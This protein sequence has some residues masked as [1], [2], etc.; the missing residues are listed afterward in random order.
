MCITKALDSVVRAPSRVLENLALLLVLY[1][2]AGMRRSTHG[3][4]LACWRTGACTGAPWRAHACWLMDA[5]QNEHAH[6]YAHPQRRLMP[7]GLYKKAS[8]WLKLLIDLQVSTCVPAIPCFRDS[9]LPTRL[10]PAC[11]HDLSL[12]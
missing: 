7:S 9:S 6:N 3:C 2:A 12:S 10:S 11:L 1:M 4:T 5:C 8:Q